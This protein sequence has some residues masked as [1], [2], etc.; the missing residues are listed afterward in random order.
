M[1]TVCGICRVSLPTLTESTCVV[2]SH[3]EDFLNSFIDQVL[4]L[5]IFSK[6]VETYQGDYFR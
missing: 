1:L 3:D 2:V 5:D 6:K 4:Y